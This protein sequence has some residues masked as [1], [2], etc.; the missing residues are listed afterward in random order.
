[1]KLPE[2]FEDIQLQMFLLIM[3]FTTIKFKKTCEN[4]VDI[5]LSKME[6]VDP[7]NKKQD[8]NLLNFN[9]PGAPNAGEKTL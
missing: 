7:K 9:I 8:I 5:L 1:L 3:T 2:R 4:V 6:Q